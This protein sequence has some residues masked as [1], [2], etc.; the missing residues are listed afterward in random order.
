MAALGVSEQEPTHTHHWEKCGLVQS[1][2][3]SVQSVLKKKKLRIDLPVDN[4]DHSGI[5]LKASRNTYHKDTWSSM[6]SANYLQ[7]P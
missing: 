4:L 5:Y 7:K 6:F 2:W 1:L 3:K